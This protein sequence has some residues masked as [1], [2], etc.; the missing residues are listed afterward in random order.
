MTDERPDTPAPTY[1]M[2]YSDEFRQLLDRR[3]AETHAAYLLPRLEPG[4]RVLDFGCGPGTITVGL[5]KLVEPGEV[6]GLDM[7]ESQIEIAR[8]AAADGGHDNA[9]FHVGNVLD[10]PFEDSSFDVAHC[11]AVLMHVPDVRAV[12]A[13][14]R[15]VLKPGGI[16][17]GREMIV[18]SSFVEPDLGGL[19]EAWGTFSK[20]IS[21]NG[22]HPEMGRQLK[23]TLIDA[24]F[25][26]IG[27][28]ASFESFGTSIDVAFLHG[29]V[30]DWF[31]S[32]T[33]IEAATKYGLTTR[34]EFDA[35]R[36]LLDEWKERPDAFAAFAWGEAVGH[37][38]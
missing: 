1:T 13:E 11:H 23:G 26:D 34:E 25:T 17:A 7:E 4:M 2:G 21:A 9:A 29:F 38:P 18:S 14:V 32:P 35:F 27:T 22:G 3:S 5:A 19:N 10:L 28:T 31:L 16:V 20:L 36:R 33:V 30:I 37:K 24:G 12:L 15:R 6:H 8:A